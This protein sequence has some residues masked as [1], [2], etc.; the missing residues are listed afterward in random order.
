MAY[1]ERQKRILQ[2]LRLA[3]PCREQARATRLAQEEV[4]A[5][6]EAILGIRHGSE[7]PHKRPI[8]FLAEDP[9]IGWHV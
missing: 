6:Q 2:T 3:N 8:P 7:S 5:K 1:N 9:E 4:V